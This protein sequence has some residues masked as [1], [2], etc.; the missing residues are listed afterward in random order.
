MRHVVKSPLSGQV[1]QKKH[2]IRTS[3]FTCA[4]ITAEM[5]LSFTH[6]ATTSH[7]PKSV[8]T[9]MSLMEKARANH[10]EP[11]LRLLLP[12]SDH[13][14]LEPKLASHRDVLARRG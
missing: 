9:A 14:Q 6:R 8:Q 12:A 13:Q 7:Y 10:W 1:E 11:Y 3:P 5:C 4:S 2:N